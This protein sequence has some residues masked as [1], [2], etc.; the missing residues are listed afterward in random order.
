MAV[1]GSGEAAHDV[2]HDEAD[3]GDAAGEGDAAADE[4]GDEEDLPFFGAFDVEAE[5]PGGA[6]AE[7]ERVQHAR[8]LVYPRQADG[9]D[10]GEDGEFLPVHFAEGAHAP[11]GEAAQLVVVG[12]VGEQAGDGAGEAAER[13]A[14]EEHGGDVDLAAAFGEAVEGEG[15]QPAAG[16]GGDGQGVVAQPVQQGGE[17]FGA[18]DDVEGD[19]EGGAAHDA[20]DAG[21]NQR[22]AE[23]SLHHRAAEGEVA[24]DEGGG[25][26]AW[27]AHLVEGVPVCRGCRVR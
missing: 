24:A 14:D 1:V 4:E 2:R 27:Q 6:F 16:E 21:V 19:A 17:G 13:D 10:G 25:E 23:E 12:D 8:V 18:D 5:V 22:V 15:H 11:E 20:D 7:H 3:E 26:R 9:A